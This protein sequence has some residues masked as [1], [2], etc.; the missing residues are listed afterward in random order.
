MLS[1]FVLRIRRR[2]TRPFTLEYG[3]DEAA[4]ASPSEARVDLATGRD[5]CGV[6]NDLTSGQPGNDGITAFEGRE[7][8]HGGHPSHTVCRGVS[9]PVP[10][11]NGLGHGAA[12]ARLGRSRPVVVET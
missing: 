10:G 4:Q 2:L 8:A 3:F 1:A 6:A 12:C 11:L 5:P 9:E 7:R